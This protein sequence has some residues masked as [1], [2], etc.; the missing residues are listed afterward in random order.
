MIVVDPGS[1]ADP[2]HNNPPDQPPSPDPPR[3]LVVSGNG[4]AGGVWADQWGWQDAR[5]EPT[6]LG[7]QPRL[8]A[9]AWL[10]GLEGLDVGEGVE[11]WMLERDWGLD[12]G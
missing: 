3:K 5:E 2:V 7:G 8:D 1:A 9:G 4:G 6:K 12:V 10:E 11:G